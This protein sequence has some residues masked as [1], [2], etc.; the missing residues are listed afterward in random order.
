M[1]ENTEAKL[2]SAADAG[3]LVELR[4]NTMRKMDW[5]CFASS[6]KI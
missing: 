1:L 5:Q 2:L 4:A 3:A 6:D